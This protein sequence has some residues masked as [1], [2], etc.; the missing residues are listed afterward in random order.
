MEYSYKNDFGIWNKK[1]GG[2]LTSLFGLPFLLI[3]LGI[4][5]F[6][7]PQ[8]NE[9]QIF[10][11]LFGS[12]FALVGSII[13]FG[14]KGITIDKTRNMVTIWYGLLVPFK[15]TTYMLSSEG[16]VRVSKEK[17][18]T[19]NSSYVVYPITLITDSEEIKLF[20][21]GTFEKAREDGEAI[22]KVC[23][24]DLEEALS[25]TVKTTDS[26]NLD[27]SL[28]EKYKKDGKPLEPASRPTEM[29]SHVDEYSSPLRI[30]IPG[31]SLLIAL[32]PLA[33]P[34]AFLSYFYYSLSS[35]AGGGEADKSVP[36]L[37]FA[38][39]G[40]F[41][42]V[43]VGVPL[44]MTLKKHTTA[45]MIE[46]TNSVLTITYKTLFS[47]N[48][49]E[50]PTPEIED[51]LITKD[52]GKNRSDN[53]KAIQIL[54]DRHIANF[55]DNLKYEEQKYLCYLIKNVLIDSY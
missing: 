20:E 11:I 21:L 46:V 32:L 38:F 15:S 25:G 37:F 17:R 18:Q 4:L 48:K 8:A 43:S 23:Q 14:R 34:A 42:F 7:V 29:K 10:L 3:G 53:N 44:F 6:L 55:G 5:I 19:K 13:V 35:N 36:V 26:E 30:V 24:Y 31:R 41:A 51:I 45:T 2:G 12:I 54:S 49:F 27:K 40:F 22:A 39:L 33:I 47:F 28:K 16:K 1:L 52:F 50:I 9:E